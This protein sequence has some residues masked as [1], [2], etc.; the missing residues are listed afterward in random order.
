ML[1]KGVKYVLTGGPGT[2]K[3]TLLEE[4]A[5][6]GYQ[7]VPEAARQIIKEE[8]PKERPV[9]P[10]TDLSE[11][12]EKVL[13]RQ[14]DL[15][16]KISAGLVFLDRGLLDSIAYCRE[17][18]ISLPETLKQ[19]VEKERHQRRYAGIFILDFLP[20]YVADGVR[21]EEQEEAEDLHFQ[22]GAVYEELYYQ[23]WHVPVLSPAK[24]A[25]FILKYLARE[26]VQEEI[27]S[28]GRQPTLSEFGA[29]LHKY[30]F[31][32]TYPHY[33]YG[34][35]ASMIEVSDPY[36][37]PL[38]SLIQIGV[39]NIKNFPHSSTV[40]AV[41][42]LSGPATNVTYLR[43]SSMLRTALEKERIPFKD[44]R[45]F[46]ELKQEAASYAAKLQALAEEL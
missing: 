30:G 34:D 40:S 36:S 24:R 12:Q 10:W 14:L 8:M 39:V 31:K 42:I 41:K 28:E 44:Q 17:G 16:S 13:Q 18:D 37:S 22:I 32:G 11:F 35:Y 43:A 20:S 27:A 2:G 3:S 25:Q 5:R 9:L 29:V 26:R 23:C 15:E 45:E 19:I 33:D 4:L 38:N 7:T 6:R 1:E 46:S 21:R